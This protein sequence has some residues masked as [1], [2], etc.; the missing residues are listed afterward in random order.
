MRKLIDIL[1]YTLYMF[2]KV[3]ET[4]PNKKLNDFWLALFAYFGVC[5][6]TMVNA[7]AIIIL[8]GDVGKNK[9]VGLSIFILVYGINAV[10]IFHR[11]HYKYVIEKYKDADTKTL[12]RMA[13]CLVLYFVLSIGVLF[14]V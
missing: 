8:L 2:I 11:K 1:F 9:I 14:V 6:L 7:I 3:Y 13:F 10:L 5:V 12:K 4:N